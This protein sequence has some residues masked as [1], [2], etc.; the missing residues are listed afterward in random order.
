MQLRLIDE[1]ESVSDDIVDV[2]K[3]HLRLRNH[4][5][6]LSKAQRN[7]LL[8]LHDVVTAYFDQ[9]HAGLVNG[10]GDYLNSIRKRSNEINEEVRTLRDTHWQRLSEEQVE[11]LISTSYMDIVN[12]YRRM[13]DHLLNIGEAIH[14]DE[15]LQDRHLRSPGSES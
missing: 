14:S 10:Q 3:L 11:P 15:V 8:G 1:Y 4:A 12:T 2:L 13:K 5:I 6:K 7:E 9:V